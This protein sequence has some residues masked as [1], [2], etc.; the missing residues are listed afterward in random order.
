MDCVLKGRVVF[1]ALA[2][3]GEAAEGV[4]LEADAVDPVSLFDNNCVECSEVPVVG[5]TEALLKV[6]L[7]VCC[8]VPA[9]VKVV[10]VVFAVALIVV[11][12]TPGVVVS[13]E[14][15]EVAV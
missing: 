5:F 8:L 1:V 14:T 3:S 9:V 12:C 2:V 13:D 15:A 6:K 7:F 4:A 10:P 11:F